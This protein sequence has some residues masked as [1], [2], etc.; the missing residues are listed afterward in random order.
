[1]PQ[2]INAHV[3]EA[4]AIP[5]KLIDGIQ[6]LDPLPITVQ[7]LMVAVNT[8]NPNT[9]EIVG[10][11]EYDAAVASNILRAANS[12]AYGG[13]FEV[14]RV[15]DAVVRLGITT[16]LNIVLGDHLKRIKADPALYDLTQEDLWLHGA[17]ASLAVKAMMR[18]TKHGRIPEAATIAALVHD[19][20]K[21]VMVRFLEAD[22]SRV[23]AYCEEKRAVWVEAE[24]ELFGCDHAQVGGAMARKWGFP[25]P[26]R[27]AIEEHHRADTSEPTPIRDAVMLA[28]LAAKS[29][30]AGLGAAGLN[31]RIDYCGC[32]DRLG[33]TIEGFEKA[34]AQTAM[35]LQDLRHDSPEVR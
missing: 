5:D 4:M 15:R 11:I 22:V 13:R 34:C 26:I 7:R 19:I 2:R 8:E 24:R 32:R 25:E 1:M 3:G 30:G 27:Q 35:W 33:L 28:N 16:L 20:G 17:A 18:E 9:N 14:Q 6:R 21:L 23:R 10:I 31:F 12:A 29:V